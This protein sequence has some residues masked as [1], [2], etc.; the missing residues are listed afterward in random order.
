VRPG[1]PAL[2]DTDG[3]HSG[4]KLHALQMRAQHLPKSGLLPLSRIANAPTWRAFDGTAKLKKSSSVK[5]VKPGVNSLFSVALSF[6]CLNFDQSAPRNHPLSGTAETLETKA[7]T[8]F[9]SERLASS[10]NRTI[11]LTS[12]PVRL[13]VARRSSTRRVPDGCKVAATWRGMMQQRIK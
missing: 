9:I 11:V 10:T 5:S 13:R 2:S 12:L 8:F 6:N 4:S 3:I 1:L 7:V